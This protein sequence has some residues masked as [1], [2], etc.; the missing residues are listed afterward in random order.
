[1]SDYRDRL[2]PLMASKGLDTTSLAKALDISYQAVRKVLEGG[3]FG[4]TNNR[5]AARLFG[6]D[7]VWLEGGNP[8]VDL[9]QTIQRIDDEWPAFTLAGLTSDRYKALPESSRVAVQVAMRSAIEI[10]EQQIAKQESPK[11]TPRAA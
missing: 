9:V 5:K 10:E 2:L 8:L 7:P 3:A 4:P 6:V 1:M 11:A